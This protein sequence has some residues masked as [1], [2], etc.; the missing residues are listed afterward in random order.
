MITT[1]RRSRARRWSRKGT[2]AVERGRIHGLASSA[3]TIRE[4]MLP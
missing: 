3:R 1:A 2:S 4:N